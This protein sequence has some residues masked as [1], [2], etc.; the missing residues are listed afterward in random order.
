MWASTLAG[1][2]FNKATM[3]AS[4]MDYN[5]LGHM[6]CLSSQYPA[7]WAFCPV[8]KLVRFI[9]TPANIPRAGTSHLVLPT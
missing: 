3:A 1:T 7:E 8:R 9:T 6:V 4:P 5:F 2:S